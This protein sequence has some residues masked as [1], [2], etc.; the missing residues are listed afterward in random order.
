MN[1]K[2]DI[3]EKRQDIFN[4]TEDELESVLETYLE[5]EKSPPARNS[6]INLITLAGFG[7]LVVGFIALMQLFLPL[8]GDISGLLRALPIVGGLLVAAIGLGFFVGEKKKAK[9]VR[10]REKTFLNMQAEDVETE[11]GETDASPKSSKKEPWAAKRKKKLY[12]SRKDAKIFGVCGGLAQY[13]GL[14]TTLVR[15]AFVASVFLTSGSSLL[16]YPALA[17]V[18]PK[19]PKKE[20]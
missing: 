11:G 18:L 15:I 16:V 7:F 12:R 3:R 9:T 5:D 10:D 13:F 6:M 4:V 20:L 8:G 2:Q 1:S 17:F 19:E 14:D